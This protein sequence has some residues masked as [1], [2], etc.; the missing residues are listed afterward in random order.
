MTQLSS[1]GPE[2]SPKDLGRPAEGAP[3]NRR[4]TTDDAYRSH[5]FEELL[6]LPTVYARG[7]FDGRVVLITGAAGSIGTAMSVL[8]ARLGARVVGCGRNEER[9]E[10][11]AAQLERAGFSC[12][13][14]P[15]TVRD[16]E[17][18]ANVVDRA[19]DHFGHLDV[20][21]NNAGGQFAAP[22]VDITPKGWHAVLETNLYGTWY[23]M[24]AAARRWIEAEHR[25][26]VVNIATV[27]GRAAVAIPHTAASRAATI[28]LS[29]S[30]SVEWAPHDIRV[31]CLAVGVVASE[32]LVN[33]PPEAKPSFDHNP[34]R[35]LGDVHDVA[36]GAVYLASP[37]ASFVTGTT[38]EVAGG[39]Q[40][41]GEYWATGK[42]D[43]FKVDE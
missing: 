39:G 10:A 38:L 37:A 13:G 34:M 43:Y 26:N 4:V 1:S 30:L 25:G 9:L 14:V 7:L 33:Y 32:G 35:R 27:I 5:S 19:W 42:P 36:Q 16:P 28:N 3:Y 11:W 40:V 17:Q 2:P 21:I 22:A 12:L 20:V 31:N 24:Q 6:A 23:T 8:F 18:M 41:W 15:A 29:R